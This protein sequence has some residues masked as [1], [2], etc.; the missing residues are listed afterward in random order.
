MTELRSKE[1]FLRNPRAYDNSLTL[2]KNSSGTIDAFLGAYCSGMS[3]RASAED[4]REALIGEPNSNCP[5]NPTIKWMLG[6]LRVHDAMGLFYEGGIPLGRIA[7]HIR[8]NNIA[9]TDLINWIN[10]FAAP[11]KFQD[12]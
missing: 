8:A 10:Q 12:A 11:S 1:A 9:R 4:V 3:D 2:K 6:S 5:A 7:D